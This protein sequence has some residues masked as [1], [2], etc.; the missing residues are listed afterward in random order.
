[1]KYCD[2]NRPLHQCSICKLEYDSL[3]ESNP[4]QL[5][6]GAGI[7]CLAKDTNTEDLYVL[8]TFTHKQKGNKSYPYY[9][10]P[11]LP[12]ENCHTIRNTAFKSF[13]EATSFPLWNISLSYDYYDETFTGTRYV[14]GKWD[15]HFDASDPTEL[16]FEKDE[17]NFGWYNTKYLYNYT[18]GT[19]ILRRER[20][21]ML[22]AAKEDY[23]LF[24]KR[25]K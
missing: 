16:I 22:D 19:S 6:R 21:E 13:R 24:E 11:Y 9:S 10:F 2:H 5:P 15:E 12:I 17:K 18:R 8:L 3:E 1:M 23:W 20:R 4:P 7:I 14:L 25:S